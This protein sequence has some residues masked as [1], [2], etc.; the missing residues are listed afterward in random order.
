MGR[1]GKC[2]MFNLNT[3]AR[4]SGR[5]Q[6]HPSPVCRPC[7][8]RPLPG[9]GP[10]REAPGLLRHRQRPVIN[11]P[12]TPPPGLPSRPRPPR[13]A[14]LGPAQEGPGREQAVAGGEQSLGA[15]AAAPPSPFF[16]VKPHRKHL[17]SPRPEGRGNTLCAGCAGTSGLVQT[18]GRDRKYGGTVIARTLPGQVTFPL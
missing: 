3:K 14:R 17:R 16:S 4:R 5:S 2:S 18:A 1:A 8:S 13:L 6:N 12:F 9:A 11:D 15:R 7:P 10:V